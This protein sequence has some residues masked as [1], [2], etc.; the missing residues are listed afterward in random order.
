MDKEGFDNVW[1]DQNV[2]AGLKL[3]LD[4]SDEVGSIR[5]RSREDLIKVIKKSLR[6]VGDVMMMA[7]A[8]GFILGMYIIIVFNALVERGLGNEDDSRRDRS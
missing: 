1:E 3:E 2:G 6:Q 4:D 8:A 7:A 5:L